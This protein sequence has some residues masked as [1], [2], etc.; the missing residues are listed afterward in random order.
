MSDRLKI[1]FTLKDFS[2]IEEIFTYPELGKQLLEKTLEE[3]VE[4]RRHFCKTAFVSN[5][6]ILEQWLKTLIIS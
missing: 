5:V 6:Y 2:V 4:S 3:S 1:N